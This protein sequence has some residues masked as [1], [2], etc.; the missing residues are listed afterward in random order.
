MMKRGRDGICHKMSPRHLRRYVDEFAKRHNIRN[1]DTID[2]MGD[3]V[4]AWRASA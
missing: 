1:R 3:I 4:R 2:Q